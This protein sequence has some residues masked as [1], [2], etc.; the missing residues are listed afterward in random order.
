MGD[1]AWPDP[2]NRAPDGRFAPGAGAPSEE[3]V[4]PRSGQRP[5]EVATAARFYGQC[6]L[7][8]HVTRH[9]GVSP[10]RYSGLAAPSRLR[11]RLRRDQSCKTGSAIAGGFAEGEWRRS[12]SPSCT[13]A[14]DVDA[15]LAPATACGRL[16]V[17]GS[18]HHRSTTDLSSLLSPLIDLGRDERL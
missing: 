15:A 1:G 11:T 14:T 17:A 10:A 12:T 4:G 9:L 2:T 7:T 13:R 3:D 16:V 6:H 18:G 5:A 8:V